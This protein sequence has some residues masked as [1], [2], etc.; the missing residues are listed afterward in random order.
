[1][2]QH[3]LQDPNEEL[4]RTRTQEELVRTRTQLETLRQQYA[5]LYDTAP[6]GYYT[7][8]DTGT[9]LDINLTAA[10]RLDGEKL[11]FVGRPFKQY[12]TEEDVERFT[13]FLTEIFTTPVAI[14]LDE[15]RL[16][17]PDGT[18]RNN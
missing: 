7:L 2:E 13:T 16:K 11:E 9:I 6:V 17:K 8:D 14:Q 4:V 1:M 5:D 15:L 12:V 18:I 10:R 3:D